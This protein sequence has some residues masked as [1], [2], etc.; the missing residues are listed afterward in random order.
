MERLKLF[1]VADVVDITVETHYGDGKGGG[2]AVGSEIA[3]GRQWML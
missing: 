3:D 2:R 1:V